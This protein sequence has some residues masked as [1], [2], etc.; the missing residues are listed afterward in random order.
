MSVNSGVMFRVDFSTR[1]AP[2]LSA[3][4]TGRV[5]S[6]SAWGDAHI[7]TRRQPQPR[8]ELELRLYL[9]G[10]PW[11]LP[12]DPAKVTWGYWDSFTV[13]SSPVAASDRERRLSRRSG[14]SH[15]PVIAA[16]HP[17]S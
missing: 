12:L 15:H 3:K 1:L 7:F 10:A 9:P 16:V 8:A 14:R 4:S 5:E 13:N 2:R 6:I 17:H 11:S